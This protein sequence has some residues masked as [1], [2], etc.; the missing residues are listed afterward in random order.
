MPGSRVEY[1]R[2]YKGRGRKKRIKRQEFRFVKWGLHSCFHI[3][4][5]YFGRRTQEESKNETA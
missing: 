2:T 4:G 5:I 1:Q 3:N